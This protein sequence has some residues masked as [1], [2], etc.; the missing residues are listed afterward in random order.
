MPAHKFTIILPPARVP[1]PEDLLIRAFTNRSTFGNLT[2]VEDIDIQLPTLVNISTF[3]H[4]RITLGEEFDIQLP[5]LVNVSTFGDIEV[6]ESPPDENIQIAALTNV[7]TFGELTVQESPADVNIQIDAFVNVSTF[8][9]ISVVLADG[10]G[11][12]DEGEGVGMA[13]VGGSVI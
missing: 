12:D 3:G 5:A 13:P 2:V 4:L 6:Q 11:E 8:G 10:A 9:S 1:G 7:S